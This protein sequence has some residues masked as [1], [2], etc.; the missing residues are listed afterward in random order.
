MDSLFNA[1]SIRILGNDFL[2]TSSDDLFANPGVIE[3]R[4]T[5]GSFQGFL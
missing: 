1:S 3:Y 5:G 4:F 2:M